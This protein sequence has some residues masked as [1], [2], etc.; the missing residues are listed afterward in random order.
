M[1]I[2]VYLVTSVTSLTRGAQFPQIWRTFE[3]AGACRA[4]DPSHLRFVGFPRTIRTLCIQ[5][6]NYSNIAKHSVKYVLPRPVRFNSTV[7]YRASLSARI[8]TV[9]TR[10]SE[11]FK[12]RG[13]ID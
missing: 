3:G 10:E 12:S 1:Y 13:T 5:R 6:G 8:L 9:L 11:G 2:H 4:Q 7:L